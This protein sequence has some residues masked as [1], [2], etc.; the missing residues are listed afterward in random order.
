MIYFHNP[1]FAS[2]YGTNVFNVL[3]RRFNHR[4]YWFI[5]RYILRPAPEDVGIL[6]SLDQNSFSMM[7]TYKVPFLNRIVT[8]LELAAWLVINRVNPFKIPV[9]FSAG[10]LTRGD[11][12]LAFAF[13][14]LQRP[15]SLLRGLGLSPCVKVIHLTHYQTHTTHIASHAEKM[16]PLFFAA[17]NNLSRYPYFSRHFPYYKRDTYLLPYIPQPRFTRRT[18]F[19]QREMKC[20]AMGTFLINKRTPA[21]ADAMDFFGTDCVH[22]MR[23]AIYENRE[24][25]GG[26]LASCITPFYADAVAKE[27]GPG[28][29]RLVKMYNAVW[30]LFNAKQKSYFSVKAQDLYNRYAMFVVP[31][32]VSHLPSMG[33]AE[34]MACGAAYIGIDDPMYTDLGLRPGEH[35]ITY[36]NTLQGLLD[37]VKHYQAR[38]AELERVAQR[39]YEFVTEHLS[40]PRAASLFLSDLRALAAQAAAD[41]PA[42][43]MSF[44]SSFVKEEK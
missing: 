18:P 5:G 40:G 38:P 17:E 24:A 1:H 6:I 44:K 36:D 30:N 43:K 8:L 39:G 32:E 41:T 22:P 25:A 16:A 9:R 14:N 42:E 35:Y 34:G 10:G 21:T 23:R 15:E 27:F 4:K 31:E 28:Q 13:D 33:W 12:V 29:S 26:Q 19:A 20:V 7:F 11:V 2:F 37:A 3:T